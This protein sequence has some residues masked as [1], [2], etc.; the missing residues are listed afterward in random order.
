MFN[1]KLRLES[2]YRCVISIESPH[3]RPLPYSQLPVHEYVR[4]FYD[5]IAML[6]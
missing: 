3:N 5:S 1:R 6:G 2:F 4:L